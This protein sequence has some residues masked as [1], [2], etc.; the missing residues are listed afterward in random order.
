M[1]IDTRLATALF[2]AIKSD[3][4]DL[5][6]D[7][8]EPDRKAY[9]E[10]F[11]LA[12]MRLI[13]QITNPR[14]PVEYFRTMKLALENARRYDRAIVVDLQLV[15]YPELIAEMADILLQLEGIEAVLSCGRYANDFVISVRT[16]SRDTNAG[17]LARSLVAD[18]GAGGGHTFIGGGKISLLLLKDE[19]SEEVKELLKERFLHSLGLS[20]VEAVSIL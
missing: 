10:L 17:E 20:G 11:P 8:N 2:Y 5:G 9:L 4:Q 1:Q 6:R 15:A 19:S 14:Q 16:V 13:Y 7:A 3:T 12:D 18:L